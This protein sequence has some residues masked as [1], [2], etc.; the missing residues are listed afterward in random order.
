MTD[1]SVGMGEPTSGRERILAAAQ[2]LFHTQGVA[3]TSVDDIVRAAGLGKATFYHHFASKDELV[4]TILEALAT[5]YESQVVPSTAKPELGAEAVWRTL[6]FGER[7][8]RAQRGDKGCPLGNLATEL[9]DSDGVL[10]QRLAGVFRGWES[11]LAVP[12]ARARQEGRV[13]PGV[14]P[15]ALAT[16]V[17]A[18]YEG[19]TLITR[20]TKDLAVYERATR[21]LRQLLGAEASA[22]PPP[23]APA[24][25]PPP[26]S[27]LQEPWLV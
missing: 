24:S 8:L 20:T 12:I 4:E 19:A 18:T 9:G 14:D 25:A 23:V 3:A 26:A 1:R 5:F 17:L 21:A 7:Y 11:K 10:R 16:L 2:S 27:P 22:G 15:E 6:A 13:P